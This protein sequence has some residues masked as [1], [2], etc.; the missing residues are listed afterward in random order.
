M[1]SVWQILPPD[2][3]EKLHGKHPTQKPGA[4]LE[5]ILLAASDEGDLILDPFL[6][7]GTTI[8]SA[9]HGFSRA[10]KRR[11]EASTAR[12]AFSASFS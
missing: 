5:R 2:K 12:G 8:L 10:K 3:S 6:G 1:K 4:L 11:R 9:R 7:G